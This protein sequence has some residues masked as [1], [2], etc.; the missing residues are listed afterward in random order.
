MGIVCRWRVCSSS[1]NMRTKCCTTFC[2]IDTRRRNCYRSASVD[3][4]GNRHKIQRRLRYLTLT[5]R[6]RYQPR[7]LPCSQ[8]PEACPSLHSRS[9]VCESNILRRLFLTLSL[10]HTVR[11]TRFPP[12]STDLMIWT[13]HDRTCHTLTTGDHQNYRKRQEGKRDYSLPYLPNQ[14]PG[15]ISG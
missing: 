3:S 4:V 14:Q 7:E 10:S 6:D 8:A 1:I 9:T 15:F 11:R 12:A 13:P 2:A 5:S